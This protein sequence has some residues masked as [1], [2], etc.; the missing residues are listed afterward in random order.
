MH[1]DK[2]RAMSG[3]RGDK[4][5]VRLHDAWVC[6]ARLFERGGSACEMMGVMERQSQ[7]FYTGLCLVFARLVS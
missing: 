7:I 4:D 3:D 1:K 6:L 5:H 2:T